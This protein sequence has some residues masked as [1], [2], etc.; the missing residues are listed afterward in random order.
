MIRKDFKDYKNIP[1]IKNIMMKI[2]REIIWNL[3]GN[4]DKY[5]IDIFA[6]MILM[7]C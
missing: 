1:L 7:I 6:V 3:I 5:L 2:V 4:K